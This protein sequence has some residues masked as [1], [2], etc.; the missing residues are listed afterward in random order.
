MYLGCSRDLSWGGENGWPLLTLCPEEREG[1]GLCAEDCQAFCRTHQ[2]GKRPWSV[3]SVPGSPLC[4]GLSSEPGHAGRMFPF[5]P[6]AMR[7]SH[8][9]PRPGPKLWVCLLSHNL[10]LYPLVPRGTG[11]SEPESCVHLRTA[12]ELS[13]LSTWWDWRAV[14]GHPPLALCS[15]RLASGLSGGQKR[16]KSHCLGV[17][18]GRIFRFSIYLLVPHAYSWVTSTSPYVI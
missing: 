6:W 10:P 8:L 12:T 4:W 15:S 3:M 13:L 11:L 9:I 7:G 16:K 5:I 2:I 18:S 17:A 14:L 1:G